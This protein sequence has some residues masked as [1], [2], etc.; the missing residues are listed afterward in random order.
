MKI[1]KTEL[2][3]KKN[4]NSRNIRLILPYPFT[5]KF[6]ADSE[7]VGKSILEMMS[8]KFPFISEAEWINRIEL[9]RVYI[10]GKKIDKEYILSKND[11]I[12]HHN[13]RAIE[14]SVPDEVEVLVEHEDY[15]IV[16]KP[17]PM[18]MHPGG[19]YFKNCL[20]EI[21]KGQLNEELKI[22]HRLDAVTSG[23]VLLARNKA[24]A[25]KAMLSFRDGK[26]LKT[27]V[28]LVNGLPNET[29]KTIRSS[30]KRKHGFVFESGEH[31]KKARNAV[32]HFEVLEKRDETTLI[33][34][35]PE[36]G[37]T[38]QIRLHLAEWGFPIIDDAIYGKYGD[39]SSRTMQKRA[40]SL[41]STG[42]AINELDINFS[43]NIEE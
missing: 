8:T 42:L 20:I 28:A 34:C 9:G 25:K 19:R 27:Y 36:T 17:A 32:T 6:I 16:F 43:L 1:L 29:T 18:P 21:L 5:H 41:M 39:L 11:E 10:D 4:K 14:P 24:F 12:Y 37:R 33:K 23:V 2:F 15:L 40:I 26:V 22:I 35:M 38:H 13:P 30:I 7:F 31:L 3:N